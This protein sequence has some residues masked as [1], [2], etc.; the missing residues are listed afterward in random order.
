MSGAVGGVGAL[1]ARERRGPG[2]GAVDGGG[3]KVVSADDAGRGEGSVRGQRLVG[4][5]VL[6]VVVVGEGGGSVVVTV[7]R[8]SVVGVAGQVVGVVR[9]GGH[10]VAVVVGGDVGDGGRGGGGGDGAV[11][12]QSFQSAD[13]DS[14]A[15]VGQCGGGGGGSES[16]GGG[17]VVVHEAGG[18]SHA[19]AHPDAQHVHRLERRHLVVVAQV[20]AHDAAGGVLVMH[21]ARFTLQGGSTLVDMLF[22]LCTL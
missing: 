1:R 13:S 2:G 8:V 12:H 10:V 9:M 15:Q 5:V 3:V 14:D 19:H 4:R 20:V 7:V 18:A 6:Q 22:K 11:V 16:R 17:G 21:Q